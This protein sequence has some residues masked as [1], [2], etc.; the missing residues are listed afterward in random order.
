MALSINGETIDDEI[1]EQEFRHIKSHFER[2][3]QVACCERDPEFR[4]MAKDNLMSR[5]LLQ[6]E[7]NRRFPSVTDEEISERLASLIQ[8]SGGEDQFYQSIG[9]PFKD[10]SLIREH[11]SGGVK[12]DKTLKEVYAEEP[13]P[14]E[15][16]LIAYYE[17]NVAFFLTD[18]EIR[19]SHVSISPT[20]SQSRQDVYQKLR[21]LRE[22]ALHGDDFEALGIENNT[23]RDQSP[24]LG[25]FKRGEFMEEF[26]TIA[27]SMH[28][29]EI[30]P[31]FVTQLGY[32]LCKLTGH[33]LPV[34]KPFE[35]VRDDVK[36]RMLETYRDNKF[37]EFV[38]EL[39]NKAVVEDSSPEEAEPTEH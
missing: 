38:E 10:E 9:M 23:N 39:K 36:N 15:E 14:S 37:N 2:T 21:E 7:A 29:N 20:G 5:S 24:D 19:V 25:W 27:F 31:V 11:V 30:S 6:Q 22:T 33:K 8:Q 26:E 28:L 13:E 35:E 17:A 1:I 16:E 4:A 12:L 34:P 18:E 3:L 32:H